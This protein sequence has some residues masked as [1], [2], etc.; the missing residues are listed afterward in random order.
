MSDTEQRDFIRKII[1][2]DL[3]PGSAVVV[4][5]AVWHARRPKPGGEERPRYF[6][7]V[8]YCQNGVLWPAYPNVEGINAKALEMG[9]DRDG[10]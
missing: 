9:L 2:D 7:D 5:S 3:P 10:R 1:Y 6:I 8:S 4:H